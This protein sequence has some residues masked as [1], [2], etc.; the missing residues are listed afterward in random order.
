MKLLL[1]LLITSLLGLVQSQIP[2]EPIDNDDEDAAAEKELSHRYMMEQADQK[3]QIVTNDNIQEF[4]DDNEIAV[5]Y[6]YK[7]AEDNESDKVPDS[8]QS[9]DQIDDQVFELAALLAR[10]FGIRVAVIT[11]MQVMVD[12]GVDVNSLPAMQVIKERVPYGIELDQEQ[13]QVKIKTKK[14][15]R[16]KST[17][18]P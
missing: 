18:P 16:P 1:A 9:D 2:G 15:R 12:F 8:E 13:D 5:F 6:Y 4:L 14:K 11:D 7:D 3:L 10:K 17:S